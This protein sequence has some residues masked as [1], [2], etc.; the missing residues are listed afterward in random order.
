MS[1]HHKTKHTVQETISPYAK[2][3]T[4]QTMIITC[5]CW[6]VNYSESHQTNITPSTNQPLAATK[7][8][9]V[10][11]PLRLIRLTETQQTY[12][13]TRVLQLLLF[14]VLSIPL[15]TLFNNFNRAINLH[16]IT[17]W[18]EIVSHYNYILHN[19]QGLWI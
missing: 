11:V 19:Y 14:T 16:F 6:P 15:R 17:N 3:L 10:T 7:I 12:N 2:E 5:H 4:I 8:D 1:E 9:L 13:S 18:Y